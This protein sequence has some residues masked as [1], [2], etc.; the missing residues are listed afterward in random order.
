MRRVGN[1]VEQEEEEF[2]QRLSLAPRRQ[3][4]PNHTSSFHAT[5]DV[6][7]VRIVSQSVR[8]EDK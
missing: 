1:F 7:L 6:K 4:H 5:S 3:S 8:E 2:Q